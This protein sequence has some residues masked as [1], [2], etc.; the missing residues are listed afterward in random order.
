MRKKNIDF[1]SIIIIIILLS[2]NCFTLYK[3]WDIKNE[4]V[5]Q[6]NSN[7]SN[8]SSNLQDDKNCPSENT[9]FLGDSITERAPLDELYNSDIPIVNSGVGGNKTTDILNNL[10]DRV[11]KY[12]P[13]RVFIQVGT[14]DL[15]EKIPNE[16]I[17]SNIIKIAK[18]I[19][20]NVPN[21]TVYIE[22][23]YPISKSNDKKIDS[24]TVGYRSN[25]NIEEINK[26][27]KDYCKDNQCTYIDV[28]SNLLDEDKNLA[29]K[30]TEE[31][32]HLSDL[33][34]L[35]VARVID[36]YLMNMKK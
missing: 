17:A 24:D 2:M 20:K 5:I 16:E 11:Y 35:K 31:G 7:N 14:N 34:Y 10:E 33:G 25:D 28:Y 1:F 30:Y 21:T 26:L 15:Y 29:T 12:N 4:L 23:I 22:S 8:N 9:V 27:L 6:R 36:P 19:H 3:F 32:L 13:A 18:L